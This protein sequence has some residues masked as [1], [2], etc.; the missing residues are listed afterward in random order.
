M[1]RFPP[2]FLDLNFLTHVLQLYLWWDFHHNLFC[3]HYATYIFIISLTLSP[4]PNL[5]LVGKNSIRAKR[6]WKTQLSLVMEDFCLIVTLHVSCTENLPEWPFITLLLILFS[7][8]FCT[9]SVFLSLSLPIA[10][11]SD[12][13]WSASVSVTLGWKWCSKLWKIKF[14][15]VW[16]WDEQEVILFWW[17]SRCL[18]LYF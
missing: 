7:L 4:L 5:K 17:Q 8:N 14:C 16:S 3:P 1:I 15:W 18:K 2:V 6:D 10:G 9:V 13:D 11:I 12:H